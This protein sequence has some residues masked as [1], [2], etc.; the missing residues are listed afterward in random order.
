MPCLPAHLC[1]AGGA[2]ADGPDEPWLRLKAQRSKPEPAQPRTGK[3]RVRS[4][5]RGSEAGSGHFPQ[6]QAAELLVLIPGSP[7]QAVHTAEQWQTLSQRYVANFDLI[8]LG[9][10]WFMCI[11]SALMVLLPCQ[12]SSLHSDVYVAC[13]KSDQTGYVKS[14]ALWKAPASP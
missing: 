10:R 1:C 5:A 7:G 2:E 8:P 14:I 4:Y 12:A 13:S 9:V 3:Q 11:L 6:P